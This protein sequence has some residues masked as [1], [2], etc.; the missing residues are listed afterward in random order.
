MDSIATGI[1]MMSVAIFL[2]DLGVIQ[3]IG[4]QRRSACSEI[5]RWKI[6][7]EPLGFENLL[8]F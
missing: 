4:N 8:L 2:Q 5:K 6:E 1:S 7:E 3:T